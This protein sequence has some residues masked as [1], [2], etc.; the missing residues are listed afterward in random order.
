MGWHNSP[1]RYGLTAQ[2]FHWVT[3]LLVVA[4]FALAS[5]FEEM[6]AGPE[7]G[8]VIGWHK[9]IGITVLGLVLMRLLWRATHVPPALPDH[10][11]AWEKFAAKAAHIALY[12]LML[13]MPISGWLHD[14]A[15]KAA[16]EIKM[17][18]FGLFEWPRIGWIMNMEP[19]AK[20]MLHGLF[21]EI[22]EILAFGLYLLV[23]LHIAAALKHQFVD[24][25]AELQRMWP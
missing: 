1:K 25:E 5:Y 23:A 6:P 2:L 14:S 13:A 10:Y 19:A 9:S 3:L 12:L 17:Y 8:V 16:P 15:W 24:K 4:L 18:W 20:E 22:H 11:R 21:G 7:K